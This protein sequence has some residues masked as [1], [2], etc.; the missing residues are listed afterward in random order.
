MKTIFRILSVAVAVAL[1]AACDPNKYPEFDDNDAFAAF[2]N[3]SYSVNETVGSVSLPVT[4][5]SVNTIQTS[6]TYELDTEKSTAKEGEDFTFADNSGVLAFN[7]SERTKNIQINIID[8]SGEYTGDKSIVIKIKNAV[9]INVGAENSCSVKILDLDHPLA[10]VLGNYT[11]TCTD[12]YLGAQSYTMT[13]EKDPEDVTI[14]WCNK[15]AP[16]VER[17]GTAYGSFSVWGTVSEDHSTIVFNIGQKPGANFGYGDM[18]FVLYNDA[19]ADC[20]ESG[21]ITFTKQADG[22]FKTNESYG[23]VDDEYYWYGGVVLG[24]IDCGLKGM[25]TASTIWTKQ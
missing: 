3:D 2:D 14:V 24:D 10:D 1:A 25:T 21:T 8:R 4:I 5:A 9:G 16:I 19:Y 6:V 20:T 22:T 17:Y 11:V 23:F 15:I 7:G 18:V 12:Y 13:L